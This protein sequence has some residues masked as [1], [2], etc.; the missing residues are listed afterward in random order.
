MRPS[1][2]SSSETCG[3]T[4]ETSAARKPRTRAQPTRTRPISPRAEWNRRHS[5]L[6]ADALA[7]ALYTNGKYAEART[8]SVR[9]LALGTRN[10]SFWFHRGMIERALGHRAAG[11]DALARALEINALFSI[12]W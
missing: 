7:W 5:V 9:A 12:R 2:V 3:S 6:V 10:A 4:A 8:Y 11:R 1:P